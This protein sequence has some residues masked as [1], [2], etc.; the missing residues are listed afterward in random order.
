VSQLLVAAL[1]LETHRR[2]S[3]SGL[4]VRDVLAGNVPGFDP[5]EIIVE[6]WERMLEYDEYERCM[7]LLPELLAEYLVA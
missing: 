5:V 2:L 4:C 6:V 7:R 1:P 3:D